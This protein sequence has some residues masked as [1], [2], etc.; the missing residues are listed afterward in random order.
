MHLDQ[1]RNELQGRYESVMDDSINYIGESVILKSCVVIGEEGS[2]Y[3]EFEVWINGKVQL[4]ENFA[5]ATRIYYEA[6]NAS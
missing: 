1:F 6:V 4:V 5:K 3:T 2:N